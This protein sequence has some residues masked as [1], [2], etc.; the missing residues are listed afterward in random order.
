MDKRKFEEK[1]STTFN[2]GVWKN[3]LSNEARERLEWF[4]VRFL[5][6]QQRREMK[7][8]ETD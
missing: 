6:K 8:D 4:I 3:K 1:R 2:N 7:G 5:L